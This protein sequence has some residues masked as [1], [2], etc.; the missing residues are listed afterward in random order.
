MG[1]KQSKATVQH[2]QRSISV[3]NHMQ[4]IDKDMKALLKNEFDRI[5]EAGVSDHFIDDE[6]S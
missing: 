5:Q 1:Q 6:L 4:R 3:K 2:G